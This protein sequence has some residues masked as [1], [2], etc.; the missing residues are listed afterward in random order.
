[1][2]N[3][4]P[5]LMLFAAGFGTRMRP[6]T[7]DMPKPLIP[8][9]G[10]PLIDHATALAQ[11]AEVGQM[12]ANLHYLPEQLEAHL[13][14]TPVE[15]ITETP[16]ILDTGGGLRNALPTLG[17]NPVVT[18]N[19]DAIWAGPNPIRHLL[20]AWNPETMDALLMCIPM[21]HAH[22]RTGTGDFDIDRAGTLRR[23]T[24]ALYGGAQIMKTDL[25]H[26][27]SE[28]AF[29]LNV[30]WNMMA[31]RDRLFGVLYPGHWCD[32]GHPGGIQ[33]AQDM[34]AAHHV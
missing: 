6:L 28:T 13:A 14:N 26:S 21:D 32:V 30:V 33:E 3:D 10:K 2:R 23:G 22:G 5:A 24:Q 9:A 7:D 31:A 25:L 16:D 15:T 17:T 4:P 1:M 29:S 34:L 12:V 18:L 8:V 27:V 20:D 19:T 11:D